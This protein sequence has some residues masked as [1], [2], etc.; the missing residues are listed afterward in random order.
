MVQYLIARTQAPMCGVLA[1]NNPLCRV[2]IYH[3]EGKDAQSCGVGS[4]LF[5]QIRRVMIHP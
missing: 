4:G 3:F 1:R 2:F 5:E